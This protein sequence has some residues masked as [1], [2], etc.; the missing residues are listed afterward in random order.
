MIQVLFLLRMNIIINI[1][2]CDQVSFIFYHFYM[3][4]LI[5]CVVR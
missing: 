5:F 1:D 2:V 3:N 4:D